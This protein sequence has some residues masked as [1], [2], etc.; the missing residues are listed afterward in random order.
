[1]SKLLEKYK[2]EID[3]ELGEKPVVNIVS[4]DKV[5]EIKQLNNVLAAVLKELKARDGFELPEEVKVWVKNQVKMPEEIKVW[6]RNQAKMP[7][8]IRVKNLRDIKFPEV[9]IPESVDIKEAGWVGK[10]IKPV[11]ESVLGLPKQLAGEILRVRIVNTNDPSKPL[12]VRLSNGRRFYEAIFQ[13][14]G[15][16]T[17]Y[18]PF[19]TDSGEHKEALVNSDGSL[20]IDVKETT[21]FNGGPET[22]GTSAVELTFTG[23]TQ[24]I[25]VQADHDN[26]GTVWIG[27]STVDNSGANAVRRL[28]AGEALDIDLNDASAKVYAV[29]D[30][31]DQ[32]VYKLA[33][34]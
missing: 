17:R 34:T 26:T 33:L 8:E 12:A 14:V 10:Y 28:E 23:G 25:G 4:D 30:T 1:M 5:E 22:I 27:P 19:V 31:A 15:Q 11:V 2:D 20:V 13:A 21:G 29:S 18:V 7:K 16:S 24:A 3:K 6:V 32:K 9:E